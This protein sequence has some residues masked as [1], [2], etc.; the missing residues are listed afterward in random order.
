MSVDL[1][2]MFRICSLAMTTPANDNLVPQ[3][4]PVLLVGTVGEG[5]KVTI[6]DPD[7]CRPPADAIE[8]PADPREA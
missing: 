1:Q 3:L 8:F 7:F 6:T 5:G 2:Y 4:R